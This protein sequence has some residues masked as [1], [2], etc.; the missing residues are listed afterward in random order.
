M[1]KTR[2]FIS[3]FQ[4]AGDRRME[5]KNAGHRIVSRLRLGKEGFSE[6][7]RG[8]LVVTGVKRR[9]LTHSTASE[10]MQWHNKAKIRM[11]NIRRSGWLAK[12]NDDFEENQKIFITM[13]TKIHHL[14][15]IYEMLSD[16]YSYAAA[17]IKSAGSWRPSCVKPVQATVFC[18]SC[19][20]APG[21]IGWP[22]HNVEGSETEQNTNVYSIRFGA[23][24]CLVI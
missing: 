15:W 24:C 13:K 1:R 4:L 12:W 5:K 3:S 20:H 10:M 8:C 14:N 11:G 9:P 22:V 6:D 2:R 23:A 16:N 17:Y 19:A 18:A 7:E 21:S